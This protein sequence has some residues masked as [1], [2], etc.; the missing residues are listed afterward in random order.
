MNLNQY[1][2][3]NPWTLSAVFLAVLML[4]FVGPAWAQGEAQAS[5]AICLLVRY[6]RVFFGAL[7]L[8]CLL[9]LVMESMASS[10][11][12][13]IGDFVT[14]ILIACVFVAAVAPTA[15]SATG[16]GNTCPT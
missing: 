14:K 2:F 6:V 13:W 5:G 7:A 8:L 4:A 16:I 9:V 12:A 10:K 1:R 15:I 11:N 3:S